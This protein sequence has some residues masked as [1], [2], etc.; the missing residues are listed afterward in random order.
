MADKALFEFLTRIGDTTLVLGHRVS[1]WCGHAPALE[2]DIALANTALDLIGHTRMWLSRAGEVE[3]KGRTEDDLAFL[4]EAHEF[5]NYLLVERPNEDFAVTITR[6]FLFDAWH[7]LMLI[8]LQESSDQRVSEIAEK[9]SKEV[10]YHVERS[11]DLVVRLGDGTEESH[12]RMQHAVDILWP[13]TGE[14]FTDDETDRE[15]SDRGIIPLPSSLEGE[16][17][18]HV[19]GVLSAATLV[20]PEREYA[21]K[22]G[23]AGV[24]TEHLGFLLAE[25]QVTHRAHPG[26]TW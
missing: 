22:G 21:H 24:H 2:E 25:M 4:R 23:K 5:R 15:L 3:G 19:D 17:K 20:R 10:A 7:R 1:E 8:S 11:T 14:L 12:R 9:A 26:A 13:Y 6:Q 16:W 18:T